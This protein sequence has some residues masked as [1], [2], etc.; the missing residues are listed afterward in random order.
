[1]CFEVCD[2]LVVVFLFFFV[3]FPFPFFSCFCLFFFVFQLCSLC[4]CSQTCARTGERR[5][6]SVGCFIP[7]LFFFFFF[8]LFFLQPG[9][10]FLL[11][12]TNVS[13]FYLLVE[14]G[15]A[16]VLLLFRA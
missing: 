11:V 6:C 9:V 13:C 7:L 10:V 4:R 1:V 8:L 14:D 5:S 12:E 3:L 16:K 2:D 15:E